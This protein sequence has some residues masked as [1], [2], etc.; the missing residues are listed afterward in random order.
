MRLTGSTRRRLR[1]LAPAA[2]VAV[3]VAGLTL[4]SVAFASTLFSDNFESGSLA[5]WSRNGGSWSV[6]NDGSQVL[7]QSSTSATTRALA[8]SATW[9]DYSV[10][11]D[12]K[13]LAFNGTNRYVA[14]AARARDTNKLL[15]LQHRRRGGLPDGRR[16]PG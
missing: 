8:G 9:T 7:R 3:L 15:P 16:L 10:Q 4:S 2:G 14:L 5:N 11:A 1:W 6:V 13:P 12:V